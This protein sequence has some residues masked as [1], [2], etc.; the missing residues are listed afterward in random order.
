MG[1]V[2]GVMNNPL[3]LG[4]GTTGV[5]IPTLPGMGRW[6]FRG[7]GTDSDLGR[8]AVEMGFLGLLLVGYLIGAMVF[9][10]LRAGNRLRAGPSGSLASPLTA[11]I[12]GFL[13]AIFLGNPL[14]GPPASLLIWS[15][16]GVLLK[17][18]TLATQGAASAHRPVQQRTTQPRSAA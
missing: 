3:G 18:E 8:A 6:G 1:W 2:V 11:L 14:Y 17:L 7:I 16:L 12:V 4:L 10:A 5:G 15:S 9:H 13:P